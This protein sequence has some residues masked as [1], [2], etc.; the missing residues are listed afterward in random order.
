[1]AKIKLGNISPAATT[2][3]LGS[4]VLRD[5]KFGPVVAARPPKRG[6]AT[7]GYNYEREQ[8][9]AL[10]SKWASDPP[11]EQYITAQHYAKDTSWV[12]RDFLISAMYG[13]LHEITMPDGT[14]LI[15]D[16]EVNPS[17]QEILAQVTEI[18][19]SIL[20]R[21]AVGWVG[22][23]PSVNGYVLA[24][25]NGFPA[26]LPGQG[27]AGGGV[28]VQLFNTNGIWT[29]PPGVQRI[30]FILIGGGAGGG[31]GA[32]Q[33]S[34]TQTC[35]G[36]GGGAAAMTVHE[37]DAAL[38]NPTESITIGSGGPGGAARTTNATNGASGNNGG[39]TL[40]SCGAITL[41]AAGGGFGRGGNT[42]AQAGGSAGTQGTQTGFVGASAGLGSPGSQP[43]G[44]TS[45]G[46][47]GG[48][49]GAGQSAVPSTKNGGAG[50]VG[51]STLGMDWTASAGGIGATKVA[52]A[53]AT[54]TAFQGL[55]SM[56]GGGG[57]CNADGTA[58]DGGDGAN[59][60]SG[61]GGGGSSLNGNNSGK[62]GDGASGA[63]LVISW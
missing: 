45:P 30:R 11:A 15:P 8:E 57:W 56:G 52:P 53:A 32:R 7:E 43:V 48:G 61:G 46:A 23:P 42:S 6:P 18:H 16:R 24:L 59:Y 1:M 12:P 60:G 25:Q 34:G 2:S 51:G 37:T 9:F 17:A 41:R 63:V 13:Y 28:D 29:R 33:P 39:Q 27:F 54:Q 58:G 19:G 4:Y 20:Y 35:G 38:C 5:T 14:V 44:P 40:V 55:A 36:S 21:A 47:V 49:S 22:L 31:S 26:W 62:G 50:A 3:K 10:A